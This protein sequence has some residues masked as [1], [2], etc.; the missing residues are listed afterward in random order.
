M[1][2]SVP[3]K[4]P[5]ANTTKLQESTTSWQ[6]RWSGTIALTG[7]G[8]WNG[9]TRLRRTGKSAEK[10]SHFRDAVDNFRD[11]EDTV[12]LKKKKHLPKAT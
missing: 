10:K 2:P 3:A 6:K 4:P 7:A 8:N 9:T 12:I 11:K 1:S 5:L